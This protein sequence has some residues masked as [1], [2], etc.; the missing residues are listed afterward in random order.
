MRL[1]GYAPEN[2]DLSDL[3]KLTENL[4]ILCGFFCAFLLGGRVR[5]VF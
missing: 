2:L 4:I 5:G 1:P 3:Q